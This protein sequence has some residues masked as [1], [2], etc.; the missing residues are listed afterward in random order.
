MALSATFAE[1]ILITESFLSRLTN[2]L[3]VFSDT[4]TLQEL[5]QILIIGLIKENDTISLS[6][7]LSISAPETEGHS[8]S[9]ALGDN[10]GF[11]VSI[12]LKFSETL[13]FSDVVTSFIHGNQIQ[14]RFADGL[15]F[16]DD[17]IVNLQTIITSYLRQYLND[18][19]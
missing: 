12:I 5:L 7:F 16:S 14:L 17:S 8:D 11:L 9:M 3:G 15:L 6:D 10:A 1:N 13:F 19:I 4:F 2:T 18:A